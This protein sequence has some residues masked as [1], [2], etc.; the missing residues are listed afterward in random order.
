MWY[1]G[2]NFLSVCFLTLWVTVTLNTKTI[3]LQCDIFILKARSISVHICIH[4]CF[5]PHILFSLW[6]QMKRTENLLLEGSK[7][8]SSVCLLFHRSSHPLP[9][10]FSTVGLIHG[11]MA[12]FVF[13]LLHVWRRVVT[14]L[15]GRLA[16][17]KSMVRGVQFLFTR[18]PFHV[19]AAD[20]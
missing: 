1:F 6:D 12:Y 8:S 16:G 5:F 20:R 14:R 7:M 2:Y 9:A 17:R 19:D 18:S 13:R 15:G 11:L 4:M 10:L 3:L